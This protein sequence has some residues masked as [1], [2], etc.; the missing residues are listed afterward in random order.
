MS[1]LFCLCV[2]LFKSFMSNRFKRLDLESVACYQKAMT[3]RGQKLQFKSRMSPD[4]RA[5]RQRIRSALDRAEA[6]YRPAEIK[7]ATKLTNQVY[8]QFKRK[9]TLGKPS[10]ASLEKFLVS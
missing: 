5:R 2:C 4:E 6:D 8:T 3:P 7:E 10:L 1:S 9:L